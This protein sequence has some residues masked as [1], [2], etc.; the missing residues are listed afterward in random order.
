MNWFCY[1][2]GVWLIALIG[3][4]YSQLVIVALWNCGEGHGWMWAS[5]CGLIPAMIH[6]NSVNFAWHPQIKNEPSWKCSCHSVWMQSARHENLQSERRKG[7]RR[8]FCAWKHNNSPARHPS[9]RQRLRQHQ[10]RL[11]RWQKVHHGMRQEESD[12]DELLALHLCSSRCW[13]R[14]KCKKASPFSHV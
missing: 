11:Q 1:L 12:A 14:D 5:Y 8:D 2:R 9:L 10:S 13:F 6:R 4:K 7:E 3:I